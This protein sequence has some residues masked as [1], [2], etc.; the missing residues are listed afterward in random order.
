MVRSVGT[1]RPLLSTDLPLIALVPI[2][3]LAALLG[4]V[5]LSRGSNATALVFG[6]LTT[7]LLAAARTRPTRL[8][9]SLG[10]DI[11]PIAGRVAVAT[12]ALAIVARSLGAS[13]LVRIALIGIALVCAGRAISYLV[14]RAG[15]MRGIGSQRALI[16]G[17][18][19]IGVALADAMRLHAE[20][21]LV[22]VGFVDTV[23]AERDLPL[24]VLGAVDDVAD[25]VA[26]HGIQTVLVAFPNSNDAALARALRACDRMQA[27]VYV[28]PRFFELG[29]ETGHG[30]EELGGIPLA[31]LRRT[32]HRSAL[33]PV[34]R[35]VDIAV[36]GIAVIAVSPLLGLL[37]LAVRLTSTGPILFRQRRI[38]EN[39]RPI[40]ILKF[41][42]M[43]VNEDSDTTWNVARDTRLTPIGRVLRQSHL[44]ELPQL[45]NVLRGDMS[46]V[47]PRP[48]RPYFAEL[49]SAEVPGYQHRH[50]V[51]V[52][53][54]GWAQV[55][56]LNG[57]TSIEERVRFDNRYIER[58]SLWRDVVI[59][60]RTIPA[61][62]VGLRSDAKTT[63]SAPVDAPP[64]VV[65]LR[66]VTIDLRMFEEDRAAEAAVHDPD[67]GGEHDAR[68]NG[69]G[70]GHASGNGHG[71]ANGDGNGHQAHGASDGRGTP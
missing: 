55:H 69:S 46:I 71:G 8:T 6:A 17:A 34:K 39:G 13:Q 40:E 7:F 66:E 23:D 16:V 21:G 38:G 68:V 61:I 31:R 22:P 51:P 49:F 64:A 18:G 9:L 48:E 19:S 12:V 50:R 54:T 65:D 15:R 53:M 1:D 47:G 28:V 14:I 58:W 56:G 59:M 62:L 29:V 57:D 27:E 42:S 3:D 52:G 36:S 43:R 25:L 60:A 11:A 67:S 32:A 10:E 70:K 24:P 2:L 33:W 35:A 37:A 26:L 44:D 45:L 63:E 5:T 20:H 41:R 30:P 4:A